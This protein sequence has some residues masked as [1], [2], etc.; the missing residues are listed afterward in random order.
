MAPTLNTP[1]VCPLRGVPYPSTRW[2]VWAS[3]AIC[4]GPQTT[5]MS[6]WPSLWPLIVVLNIAAALGLALAL[7][8]LTWRRWKRAHPIDD[9]LV[10]KA[11]MRRW[12]A[13]ADNAWLN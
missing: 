5:A 11:I 2:T 6:L 1:R 3:V 4:F 8:A 7:R 12:M 10:A 13:M 9:E